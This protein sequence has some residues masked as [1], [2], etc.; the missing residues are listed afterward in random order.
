MQMS[1]RTVP[2]IRSAIRF[3]TALTVVLLGLAACSASPA[4]DPV[5]GGPAF[6]GV[7]VTSMDHSVAV[8][9][10]FIADPGPAG[11]PA[12]ASVALTMQVWNNTNTP[13]SL[14]GA[15]ITG[16]QPASL[17]DAAS[18]ATAPAKTFDLPIGAS[19]SIGLNQ[20][21]GHFLQVQCAARA[22]VPG[23]NLPM[24]FTFSN[25]ASIAA[26]VPIGRFPDSS[27]GAGASAGAAAGA[28]C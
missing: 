12:G 23:T 16:G 17:I 2:G 10:L 25:G 18:T 7:S 26:D 28:A 1:P 22:L 14:T 11:Y 8:R 15:T 27:A 13:V 5:T 4:P 19:A 9:D 24:T 20:Q 6:T 3:A 21:A